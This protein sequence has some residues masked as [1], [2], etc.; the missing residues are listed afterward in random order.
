MSSPSCVLWLFS[1]LLCCATLAVAEQVRVVGGNGRIVIQAEVAADGPV[2]ERKIFVPAPKGAGDTLDDS[3]K[4][5][6]AQ[7]D[8]VTTIRGDRVVGRV[9]TIESE[10]KLHLTAPQFEGDIVVLTAALDNVRLRPKEHGKGCDELALSN[11]DR[12]VGDI[13]AIT[14]DAV[15]IESPATGPLKVSRKIIQRISFSQPR[16]VS[17]ESQF[18]AGKIE[19]WSQRGAWNLAN[20]ALQC[21]SHGD[22]QSI[23]AKFDQKE[24][25][26]MEVTVQSAGY[27]Y[28]NCDLVL[29]AN[30][31]DGRWGR[32]SV[33]ASFQHSQFNVMVAQDGGV[34]SVVNQSMGRMFSQGTFRFAY[35]P[36]TGK[37]RA[38]AESTDLGEFAIP[39]GPKQGSYVMFN[40]RSPCRVTRIRVVR[41]MVGPTS[42]DKESDDPNHIVRFI[43]KDRVAATEVTLADGKLAL[44]TALGDITSDARRIES[45]TFR[46]KG[47]EKPRRNKGDVAIETSDTRLT[48]QFDRLTP[49]CLIGKSS[50]LGEVKVRRDFLTGIQFNI[51]K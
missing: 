17:L 4:G 46:A 28:I 50:Y 26:T 16:I 43:N 32:N 11:G 40:S 5:G 35:D 21:F 36:A 30:S 20:G 48:V 39:D 49:E 51:Y 12:I 2:G 24:A 31:N 34:N 10:G 7:G 3:A 41:G 45:I 1:G 37:A 47:I 22:Q 33:L 38:W 25:V 23:F 44:K 19:P 9:V 27:P 15:I 8:V 29:F 42:V 14:P 6:S 18:E 13:G